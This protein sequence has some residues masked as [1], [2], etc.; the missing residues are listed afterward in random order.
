[1]LD[2][3]LTVAVPLA[4]FFPTTDEMLEDALTVGVKAAFLLPAQ[5]TLVVAVTV[6]VPLFATA[7]EARIG[8]HWK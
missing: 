6:A 2:V 4:A 5:D 1:M 3:A 8:H 7:E